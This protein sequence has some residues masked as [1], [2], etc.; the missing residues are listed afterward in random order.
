M[1]LLVHNEEILQTCNVIWDKCNNR[2]DSQSEYNNENITTKT[3]QH[4][5]NFSG[6]KTCFRVL[7]LDSIITLEIFRR[8]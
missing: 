7:I 3:S 5:L 1:N 6:N 4:N 2:F 8:M